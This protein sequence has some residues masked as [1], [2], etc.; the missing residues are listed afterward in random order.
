MQIRSLTQ[1]DWLIW[2]KIRLEA[3]KDSPENFGSAHEEE[4]NWKGSDFRNSLQKNNIFGAFINHELIAC[5][6]FYKM[7]SL[8][9]KHRG[10]IWGVYTQPEQRLKG[11]SNS[12]IEA[13][14]IHAK[15][16]VI[17]IHLT[18]V[19]TNLGA[20]KLYQKHGFLIYGTEPRSLKID[21]IFF[22]EHLMIFVF[23]KDSQ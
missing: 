13:I 7:N 5:A 3:L 8:K 12:L 22:D 21:D 15:E 16:H 20:I 23:N 14:I 9:T 2:K 1:K 17:Q 19:T 10:V 6:G 11:A 18:C 4:S